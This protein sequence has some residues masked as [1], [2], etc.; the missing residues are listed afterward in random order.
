M[1]DVLKLKE[2]Y[3]DVTE[4]TTPS[5]HRVV[6]RQQTGEDDDILSRGESVMDG[7]FTANFLSGIIIDSDITPSGR[8]NKE[9][10]LNLRL[11]DKYFILIASRIFSLGQILHYEYKWPKLPNPISYEEDLG[12]YIW[13]YSQP[14]P[15][16]P[17]DEDYY[18]YRIKPTGTKEKIHEFT[19]KSGKRLRFEYMNGKGERFLINLPPE[20]QSKNQELLARNLQV[21]LNND[22]VR[23]ENFK[24]FKAF[25][26]VEIRK[27]VFD[28]DP[29]LEIYTE[30]ENPVTK[31][32]LP[33]P[34]LG[35]VDFFFPREI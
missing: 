16:N 27:E 32:I 26:M 2:V 22:W 12:L 29:I 9:D 23:I 31:E 4:L 3:G 17:S 7:S 20:K 14:F 10:V 11:A 5:G 6:I 30:I 21:W 13:D 33:F 1:K 34:I 19:I 8:L 28:N 25:E 35:S 18:E 24:S 15:N